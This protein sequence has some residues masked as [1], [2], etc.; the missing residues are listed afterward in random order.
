MAMECGTITLGSVISLTGKYITNGVHAQKGYECAITKIAENGGVT[1]NDKCYN[2]DVTCFD[3]VLRRP[4]I[5]P[6]GNNIA[7]PMV[8]RQI[9]GGEWPRRL[10]LPVPSW[11]GRAPDPV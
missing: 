1:I 6:A 10:P 3:D 2:F 8:L 7:K 9:Q 4:Q 11:T 5:R